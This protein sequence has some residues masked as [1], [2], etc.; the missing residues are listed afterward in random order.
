MIA[1]WRLKWHSATGGQTE[2]LF[3]FGFVQL[4]S[5]GNGPVYNH[6]KDPMDPFS[7]AFGY[8][9]LRWSQSAGF[10][11]VPNPRMPA[12]FSAISLDTPDGP[13]SF[14]VHS[15]FKQPSAAR[16]ARSGLVVAYGIDVDQLGGTVGPLPGHATRLG[17]QSLL[18]DITEVGGGSGVVLH[19]TTGFEVLVEGHWVSVAAL[20][21][22]RG[23]VKLSGVS[24]G[25]SKVRY[26]WYSN[27][28]GE[29]CFQCAVYV[30]VA[31]LPGALSGEESFLPLPP[32]VMDL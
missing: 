10:G 32:F 24:A 7:P 31:P 18:I 5:I 28:C 23:V 3:P 16:L 19:S 2:A 8:A 25:A 1:D 20:R 6:P 11:H 4:D 22:A 17:Q 12:V 13:P 30:G 15:P 26:A 29:S 9:G 27:P 21:H 14:N